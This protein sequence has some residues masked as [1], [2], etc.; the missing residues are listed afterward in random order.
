MCGH[1]RG[2]KIDGTRYNPP[3]GGASS[4]DVRF[5]LGGEEVDPV[6][7]REAISFA[8][9]S[10]TVDAKGPTFGI[11]FP[12]EISA[13]VAEASASL[14]PMNPQHWPALVAAVPKILEDVP[15]RKTELGG[16]AMDHN[17]MRLGLINAKLA[18]ECARLGMRPVEYKADAYGNPSGKHCFITIKLGSTNQLRVLAGGTWY[19]ISG[20][21]QESVLKKLP[22]TFDGVTIAVLSRGDVPQTFGGA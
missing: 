6:T 15:P 22:V 7:A 13:K 12:G 21:G 1:S 8:S 3:C 4:D 17:L 2:T 19:E 14:G 16:D 20:E 9:K 5:V 18:S 11:I 10:V